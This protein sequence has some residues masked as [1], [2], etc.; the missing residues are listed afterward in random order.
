MT[1]GRKIIT[2]LLQIAVLMVTT[3]G[4]T[5]E[6]EQKILEYYTETNKG[7]YA[8]LLVDVSGYTTSGGEF[9]QKYYKYLIGIAG[10]I[11]EKKKLAVEKGTIGF[12]FDKKSGDREK[13]YLGVDINTQANYEQSYDTVAVTLIRR[14]LKDVVQ[15]INSCRSIFGE[16]SIIGM[17]I[18]WKWNSGATREHVSVWIVKGDFIRYEDGMITFD[19]LV[20]RSTITNSAGRVIRL[21]L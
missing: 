17:V 15:T 5:T 2:I 12:Y 19:E 18:G 6:R 21:P 7:R 10:D 11:V 20:Q 1:N 3:C 16:S 4:L 9:H 8:D 13:L 14:N